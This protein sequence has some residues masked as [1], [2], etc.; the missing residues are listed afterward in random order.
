MA[1]NVVSDSGSGGATFATDDISAVHYPR[2]KLIHGANGVNDGFETAESA[3]VLK[4]QNVFDNLQIPLTR[5]RYK[6]TDAL[7]ELDI[8]DSVRKRGKNI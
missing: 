6:L 1:D 8:L 3:R 2:V 7:L 4:I 5:I